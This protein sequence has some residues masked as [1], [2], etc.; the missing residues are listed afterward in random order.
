MP[1][2]NDARIKSILDIIRIEDVLETWKGD[3][4]VFRIKGK[5]YF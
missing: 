4:V 1:K 3:N 2:I 5:L